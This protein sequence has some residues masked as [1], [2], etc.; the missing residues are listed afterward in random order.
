MQSCDKCEQVSKQ[1]D[2]QQEKWA[3]E[4]KELQSKQA[5]LIVQLESLKNDFNDLLATNTVKQEVASSASNAASQAENLQKAMQPIFEKLT[6]V[7]DEVVL[8]TADGK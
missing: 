1:K 8:Q 3:S 2:A 6:E 7:G 4:K 5:A